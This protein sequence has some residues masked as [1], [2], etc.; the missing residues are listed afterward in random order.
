M[1]PASAS[2]PLPALD[3]LPSPASPPA[4]P[5]EAVQALDRHA[6]TVLGLPGEVLMENAAGALARLALAMAG[7]TGRIL[8]LAGPG[9]NG[10]DGL[11][12]HRLLAP[13]SRA[14][15]IGKAAA[16][17]GLAL[18][19]WHIL[20]QTALPTAEDPEG[21]AALEQL[22]GLGRSDL[23]VDALLGTGLDRQVAGAFKAIIE[24]VNASSARV[25]A[26][27]I[28]SGLHGGSGK[29][30]GAAVRADAT[31]TFAAPK[32]GL[33]TGEG[34]CCCGPVFLSRIGIPSPAI[35]AFLARWR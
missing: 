33:F 15:L 18:L 7:D 2:C 10:G 17:K 32:T 5:P 16:L 35:D 21:S 28:P 13:R 34:P 3:P 19:Q 25:L 12:A 23:V 26:A 24:A 8:V 27:D 29:I 22:A 31:L 30:M 9:N 6:M 1:H 20:E 4:Y 11:A 14:F